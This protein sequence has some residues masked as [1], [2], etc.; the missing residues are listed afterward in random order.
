MPEIILASASPRRSEIL[1]NLNISFRTIVSSVDES[2]FFSDHPIELVK[3]LAYAKAEAVLSAAG[4]GSVIIGADTVVVHGG[5]ILG[6]PTDEAEAFRFLKQLSSNTHYV[7]T[8]IA[9]IELSGKK[10]Y[11]GYSSTKV[12]MRHLSD[13][14]ILSYIK[15]GEPM[16][17]AGAYGIQGYGA[18]LIEGI[19]GDYYNVVGLPVSKLIEGFSSL[20]INYFNTFHR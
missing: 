15:T 17:K 5:H 14:E 12:T 13:N 7:Y 19:E 4:N 6:K 8:G 2:Q 11:L 3:K 10:N 9:M 1:S 20:N 18:A 16:D